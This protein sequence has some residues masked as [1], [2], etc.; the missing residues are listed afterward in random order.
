MKRDC[1][2]CE[3]TGSVYMEGR[4]KWGSGKSLVYLNR[5]IQYKL[6]CP[7][8]KGTGRKNSNRKAA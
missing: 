1:P 6:Q 7:A 4:A 5:T 3:G 2:Q 8:C